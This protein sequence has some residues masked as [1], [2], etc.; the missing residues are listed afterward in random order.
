[1]RSKVKRGT[2]S[3]IISTARAWKA[4]DVMNVHSTSEVK[5]IITL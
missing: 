5:G 3:W 1:M 4:N 2:I